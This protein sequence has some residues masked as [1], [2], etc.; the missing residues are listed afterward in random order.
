MTGA[1]IYRYGHSIEMPPIGGLSSDLLE[2]MGFTGDS[3]APYLRA[4]AEHAFANNV[5]YGVANTEQHQLVSETFDWDPVAMRA[6]TQ[7]PF[8]AQGDDL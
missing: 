4:D 7:D 3:W 2:A 5:R 8:G 1:P 6:V